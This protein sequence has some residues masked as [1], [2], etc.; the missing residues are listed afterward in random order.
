MDK[1]EDLHCQFQSKRWK[2]F[3]KF[4]FSRTVQLK[5]SGSVYKQYHENVIQ[6]KALDDIIS[7]LTYAR[8]LIYPFY[9]GKLH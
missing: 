7:E 2:S 4:V 9:L 8:K 5:N 1:K 3:D 6:I